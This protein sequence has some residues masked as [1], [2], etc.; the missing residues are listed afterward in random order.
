MSDIERLKNMQGPGLLA[1]F[2]NPLGRAKMRAPRFIRPSYEAN[3]VDEL[4]AFYARRPRP[5]RPANRAPRRR[6]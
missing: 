2:F 4:N 3:I 6:G 1:G 5:W